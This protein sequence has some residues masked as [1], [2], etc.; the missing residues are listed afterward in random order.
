MRF[1]CRVFIVCTLL[2]SAFA[3]SNAKAQGS[4]GFE[5]GE[6]G[7]VPVYRLLNPSY[8]DHL[9]STSPAE[10]APSYHLEG[11][12]FNLYPFQFPGTQP[13]FRCFHPSYGH[14][15]SLDGACEAARRPAEG[16]LGFVLS[17][18]A[19]DHDQ[20]IRCHRVLPGNRIHFLTTTHYQECVNAAHTYDGPQGYAPRELVDLTIIR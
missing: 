6:A 14:F 2:V 18:P 4:I 5:E 11:V 8:F 1:F 19:V 9:W 10:G 7:L 20:L 15:V 16:V 3:G 17:G 12:A 13:L